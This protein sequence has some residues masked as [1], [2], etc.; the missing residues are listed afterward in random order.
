[1]KATF[2]TLATIVACV[3]HI[4]NLV[5]ADLSSATLV[6]PPKG[7][8]GHTAILANNTVFIQGGSSSANNP[9]SAS[10]A[11]LLNEDGSMN[12]ATT[13]ATWLDNT[14]LGNLD[15]RDFG[16]SAAVNGK[17]VNCGTLD[18][19]HGS[20]MVCDQLDTT[21]YN[22]T[23][24]GVPSSVLNRGGMA[25]TLPD[26]NGNIY[27]LGGSTGTDIST[28]TTLANVLSFS[29]SSTKWSNITSMSTHLRYHTATYIGNPAYE[30]IVLGGLNEGNFPQTTTSALIYAN[31]NWTTRP[32]LGTVD[33]GLRFGHT[34]VYDGKDI[35]Y[36]YGG[37][38]NVGST[39][40]SGFFYL[41]VSQSSWSWVKVGV[42]PEPRAFHAATLLKDNTILYTFGQSG[43]DIS[44]AVNTFAL[45]DIKA[46]KWIPAQSP[47]AIYNI[48]HSPNYT[49]PPP[50]SNSAGSS[51]ET[52]GSKGINVALIGGICGGLVFLIFLIIIIILIIRRRNR[53]GPI[54]NY[55]PG[56][57]KDMKIM[58]EKQDE[59]EKAKHAKAFMIRKPP[60]VYVTNETSGNGDYKSQFYGGEGS[61]RNSP[62]YAEYVGGG[63]NNNSDSSIEERRRYVEDQQRQFMEDYENTYH[64]P[65]PFESNSKEERDYD[66]DES[67]PSNRMA[68]QAHSRGA[69]P[70]YPHQETR[71][72][73]A[74]YDI[75]DYLE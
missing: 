18:G 42:N 33:P 68:N 67:L 29:N 38:P 6:P 20:S 5:S 71:Q 63:Q 37:L 8:I 31:G 70:R 43:A 61:G 75:D 32:I 23:Q 17:I 15:P 36:L 34:V 74:N 9:S 22:S 7:T 66:D 65:P 24:L 49:P 72:A 53:R 46:A 51:G 14:Q 4:P 55:I 1:M 11:I 41:N 52:S 57:P 59:E 19:A 69:G 26:P 45:F 27:L 73:S 40:S 21:W 16:I 56:P 30:V 54:N 47:N 62:S 44:T 39:P 35:I 13:N 10:Y 28:T 60:S 12:N 48:T 50:P 25:Y 58:Y 64:H 3:S 2:F